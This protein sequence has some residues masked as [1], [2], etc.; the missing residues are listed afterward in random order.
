MLIKQ[1]LLSSLWSDPCLESVK[2]TSA[3]PSVAIRS[4]IDAHYHD[5]IVVRLSSFR[6]YLQRPP[7][8]HKKVV[9]GI[10]LPYMEDC[11]TTR[12]S[13]SGL[14]VVSYPRSMEVKIIIKGIQVVFRQVSPYIQRYF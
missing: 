14:Q 3:A 1:L 5:V 4:L 8:G 2:T 7:L 10:T 13:D 6:G 11:T 9:I 12:F